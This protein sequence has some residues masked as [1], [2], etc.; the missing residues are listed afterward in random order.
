MIDIETL[1]VRPTAVVLSIGATVFDENGIQDKFYRVIDLKD[2]DR[3]PQ[4]TMGTGT[5]LWWMQQSEAARKALTSAATPILTVLDELA[6]FY[7]IPGCG[8]V[9]ANGAQFDIVILEH[10]YGVAGRK[11]PWKY[12]HVMDYRTIKNVFWNIAADKLQDGVAH[13][14]LSDAEYQT[15]HLIKINRGVGGIL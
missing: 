14:A 2:Y 4:C 1:D 11:A 12:N 7:L 3:Y 5:I 8:K 15:K 9:W 10:L 6:A 13:N